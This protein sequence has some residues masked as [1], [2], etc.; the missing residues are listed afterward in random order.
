M[1]T[2]ITRIRWFLGYALLAAAL[3]P[4]LVGT[5]LASRDDHRHEHRKHV[6]H[7]YRGYRSRLGVGNEVYRDECGA[8]HMAYPAGLLP[9]R[10]WA[11]MMKNLE[12]HFG[13]NAELGDDGRWAEIMVHLEANAA[14]PGS[15]ILR[16]ADSDIPQR[17]S[18]LP[19][20]RHEHDE[21]S[22]S[23]VADNDDVLSFSNCDACHQAA[24]KGVF[25]DDSVSIPGYGAWDD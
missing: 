18:R 15:R 22:P 13:E 20:F 4:I 24:A 16:G 1:S 9:A 6:D 14:R 19:W 10:S 3:M 21:L 17:I 2:I 23:Q 11:V 7:D 12:D 8:C 25:D 5:V